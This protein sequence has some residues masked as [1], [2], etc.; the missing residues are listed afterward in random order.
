MTSSQ[1]LILAC[2]A[3]VLLTFAVGLRLLFVR[4]GEMRAN[5]IH[6]QSVSTRRQVAERLKDTRA[7]DNFAHLFEVPVLFY[8][9]CLA[10]VASGHIPSWLPLFAWMFVASR[11]IHSLIQ[12]TYNKVMHRFVVFLAGFGLIAGMWIAYAISF[13]GT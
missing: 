11:V 1:H 7:S 5:R 2:A 6:P 13:L 9:F 3:M 8:A 12:C 4:V 10:A